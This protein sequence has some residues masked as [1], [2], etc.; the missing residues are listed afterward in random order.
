[1]RSILNKHIF[2]GEL[3]IGHRLVHWPILNLSHKTVK[4]LK[5]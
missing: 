4:T 5:L 2:F 1:M 3:D